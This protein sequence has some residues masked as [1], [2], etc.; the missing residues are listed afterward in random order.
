MKLFIYK[1]YSNYIPHSYILH[2]NNIKKMNH[3]FILSLIA[4]MSFTGCKND[5]KTP[6]TKNKSN[7]ST[8]QKCVFEATDSPKPR[9]IRFDQLEDLLDINNDI[10]YIYTFFSFDCQACIQ[11]MACY[12]Q[13][14]SELKPDNNIKLIYVNLDTSKD[15]ESKMTAFL[16]QYQ[17]AG[18]VITL[19][20]AKPEM[21]Y[22]FIDEDWSG[23]LPATLFV[24]N[25]QETWMF[26]EKPFDYNEL[27]A[28][29]QPLLTFKNLM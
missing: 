4:V 14:Y 13:I 3:Y 27:K 11:Q 1:K 16:N 19:D 8:I 5:T 26:Y 9:K 28:V 25:S 10:L 6:V 21:I 22:R 17:F 15:V 18:Q 24:D 29:I 12:E 20:I 2:F 23:K 7:V